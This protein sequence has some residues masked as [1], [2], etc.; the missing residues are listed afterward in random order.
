MQASLV[1][2]MN[3]VICS[4]E[5]LTYDYALIGT[6]S[7]ENSVQLFGNVPKIPVGFLFGSSCF[8]FKL[9][10]FLLHSF[11]L[12]N[13]SWNVPFHHKYGILDLYWQMW[14][15]W[16]AEPESYRSRWCAPSCYTFCN[17]TLG[18]LLCDSSYTFWSLAGFQHMVLL[19]L[20]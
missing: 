17:T 5:G 15:K 20:R 3:N 18:K 8:V 16:C 1:F 19:V 2:C 4:D 7:S 12:D 13:P 10:P 11:L 6:G 14:L 9:L